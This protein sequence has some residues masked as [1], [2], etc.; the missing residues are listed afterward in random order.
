MNQ[1]GFSPLLCSH[2]KRK[3]AV[4]RGDGRRKNNMC[5]RISIVKW[6]SLTRAFHL[7][8]LL[9]REKTKQRQFVVFLPLKSSRVSKLKQ[10]TTVIYTCQI[11]LPVMLQS[12]FLWRVCTSISVFNTPTICAEWG[13]KT[14]WFYSVKKQTSAMSQTTKKLIFWVKHPL[15]SRKKDVWTILTA[16]SP[17]S[18]TATE[19]RRRRKNRKHGE[20]NSAAPTSWS[21]AP[22]IS[23]PIIGVTFPNRLPVNWGVASPR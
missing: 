12:T 8:Q 5:M 13:G 4:R 23:G 16:Q 6:C 9:W 19:R 14:T 22:S 15:G 3:S 2:Q 10:E 11:A 1:L 18:Q 17:R 20:G 7:N 21:T